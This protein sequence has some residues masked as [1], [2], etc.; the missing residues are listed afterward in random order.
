MELHAKNQNIVPEARRQLPRRSGRRSIAVRY[1][2][3]LYDTIQNMIAT[4]HTAGD[5]TY[6]SPA[7]YVRAALRAYR[8]G[9]TLTELDRN[10]EKVETSLRL[11]QE[12]WE[13]W[14]TLPDQLRSR[15][16]ERAIRTYMRIRT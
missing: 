3:L 15:L 12:L 10:G 4:A 14:R 7:D 2:A 16:L 5:F 6:K 11:D 1:N 13:F 8:N 9:M